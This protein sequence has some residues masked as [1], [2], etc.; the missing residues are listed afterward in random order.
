[1]GAAMDEMVHGQDI[2]QINH[3]CPG[4]TVHIPP[5]LSGCALELGMVYEQYILGNHDLSITYLM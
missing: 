3:G 4:Y 2:K 5:M 1:M